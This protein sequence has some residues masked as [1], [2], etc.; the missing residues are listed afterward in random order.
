MN[1]LPELRASDADRDAAVALLREHLAA[2]RLTLGEFTERMSTAYGA[3]TTAELERLAR[4][5]PVAAAPS[6][7]SPTQFLLSI[8]GSVEREGRLRIRDRVLSLTLFGNT[9][10]DLRRAS[11]EGDVVT[12]VTFC[13]FGAAD[14]Y[15]PEG[16]EVDVHGLAIFGHKGTRGNDPP[17]Q[18]G[19][20][21][22]R[23]FALALFAGIDVWRVPHAW[24]RRTLG[25][26]IE[27]IGKGE[28]RER[29]S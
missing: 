20:P 18:A 8:F 21:L 15:V 1:D 28:H 17:A 4:D 25:E 26:I 24:A 2:G 12:I 9:D 14:V 11:L 27:G 3:T 16:I 7:R 10:L 6:R 13:I 23:V 29:A 5:M 19:T 22:V